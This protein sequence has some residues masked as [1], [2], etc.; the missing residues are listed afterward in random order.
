MQDYSAGA[1]KLPFWFAEFRRTVLFLQSGQ[2]AQALR[3]LAQE[4]N[5]FAA[6]TPL[7]GR[8]IYFTVCARAQ[9][10]PEPLRAL[11]A[12]AGLETQKLIALIAVMCTDALFFAFMREVYGEKLRVGG[13]VLG[14]ADIR[15]FFLDKQRES[16]TAAGWTDATLHRLL[17]CYKNYL[18]QAGLLE[19]G[20]GERKILRPLPEESLVR[21]LEAQ[22][23]ESILNCLR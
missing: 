11:F 8:Q 23:M 14:D 5:F 16:E 21:L 15:A 20:V 22:G 4:E 12:G 6:S 10:L 13:T 3:R 18:A 2:T 7:R 17:L 19:Q 9:S 1:V